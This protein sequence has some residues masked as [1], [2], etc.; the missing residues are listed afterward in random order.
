MDMVMPRTIDRLSYIARDLSLAPAGEKL[1]IFVE[2]ATAIGGLVRGGFFT[3]EVVEQKLWDV[4][5]AHKLVGL[6][7]SAA[8]QHISAVIET[9]VALVDDGDRDDEAGNDGS[10]GTTTNGNAAQATPALVTPCETLSPEEIADEI[11]RI[12]Y[13]RAAAAVEQLELADPRDRWRH[14]GE[15]PPRTIE[16]APEAARHHTPRSTVDAFFLRRQSQ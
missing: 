14:T 16:P 10:T 12:I 11:E 5:R 4:A 2:R 8:E 3:P 13:L 15:Q 1:G 7:G 6:P 9:A